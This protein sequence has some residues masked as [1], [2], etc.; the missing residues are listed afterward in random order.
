MIGDIRKGRL[1]CNVSGAHSGDAEV[2][3]V[4]PGFRGTPAGMMTTSAPVKACSM[5]YISFVRFTTAPLFSFSRPL[6]QAL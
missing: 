6:P 5:L 4:I 2:T 3:H 1:G